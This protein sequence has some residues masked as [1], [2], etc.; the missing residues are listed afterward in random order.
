VI[1]C[2][3]YCIARSHHFSFKASP[4][5]VIRKCPDYALFFAPI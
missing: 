3:A 1:L 2:Y 4:E 5:A